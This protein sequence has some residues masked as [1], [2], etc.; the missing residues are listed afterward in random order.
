[1]EPIEKSEILECMSRSGYLMEGRI[2]RSLNEAGFFVEPNQSIIDPET[3]KS[4]E[5][6]L[7]AEV[8]SRGMK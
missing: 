3:G 4:R 6:D 5:I 2:I 1:M 7:I 8:D